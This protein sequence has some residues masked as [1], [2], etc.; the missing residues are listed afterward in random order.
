MVRLLYRLQFPWLWHG[1]TPRPS[2]PFPKT[3][4]Q[5]L[6]SAAAVSG[7]WTGYDRAAGAGPGG[8]RDASPHSP[9]RHGL[10]RGVINLNHI[11]MKPN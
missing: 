6:P 10:Y 7:L 11:L 8:D 2:L 3:G 4:T 1:K 9:G 5:M